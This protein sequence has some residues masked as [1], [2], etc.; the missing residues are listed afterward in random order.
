MVPN[1]ISLLIIRIE[2]KASGEW[3]YGPVSC[4]GSTDVLTCSVI[5]NVSHK[6]GL[7]ENLD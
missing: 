6:E 7:P 1:E 3:L 5:S 2:T 4:F